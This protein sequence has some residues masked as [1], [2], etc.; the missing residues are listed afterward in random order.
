MFPELG[1]MIITERQVQHE[2]GI[3]NETLILIYFYR[4][5]VEV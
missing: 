3:V 1:E 2:T 5:S 4:N